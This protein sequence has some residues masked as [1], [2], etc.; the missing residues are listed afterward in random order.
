[1]NGCGIA[2]TMYV[3]HIQ[4]TVDAD[5]DQHHGIDHAAGLA[6][7]HRQRVGGDEGERTD[8]V[9]RAVAELLDELVEITAIHETCDLLRD[10]MSRALTSLSMRRVETPAR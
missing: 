2:A 10:S 4:G 3:R 8:G 5:R 9:E 7:L 1:M 6:D